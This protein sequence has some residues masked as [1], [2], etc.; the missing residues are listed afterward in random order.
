[1]NNYQGLF[2]NPYLSGQQNIGLFNYQQPTYP[3]Q[4]APQQLSPLNSMLSNYDNQAN[5]F[6]QDQQAVDMANQVALYEQEQDKISQRNAM[7][8]DKRWV[9]SRKPDMS[10]IQPMGDIDSSFN[11]GAA[12]N[13]RMKNLQNYYKGFNNA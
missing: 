5:I 4:P 11:L 8:F 9:D 10:V 2:Y 1:M 7:A 13:M 3:Q 6:S 12:H